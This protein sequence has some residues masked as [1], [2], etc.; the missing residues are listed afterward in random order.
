MLYL[1]VTCVIDNLV[2][3][4]L[5][6]YEMQ[7]YVN[8]ALIQLGCRNPQVIVVST[9]YPVARVV[10][11]NWGVLNNLLPM[12]GTLS[13][14]DH[15]L[16]ANRYTND[17]TYFILA[18]EIAHIFNNHLIGTLFWYLVERLAEGPRN[19]YYYP[20][21]IAKFIFMLTSAEF[22]PPNALLIRDQEYEAD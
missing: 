9:P 1:L 20:V 13:I 16:Y 7:Y 19:E 11:L 10:G 21:E 4:F 8:R 5:K 18:H 17:E 15:H 14:D 3:I 12:T 2:V 22:L 6:L